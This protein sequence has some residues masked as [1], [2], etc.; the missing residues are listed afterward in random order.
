MA[1]KDRKPKRVKDDYVVPAPAVKPAP[2]AKKEEWAT[3]EVKV[4]SL[5]KRK[6]SEIAREWRAQIP[7]IQTTGEPPSEL[8]LSIPDVIA[9]ARLAK[10]A[11]SSLEAL[12]GNRAAVLH[13][14]IY[15]L[16]KAV[17]VEM[18][19]ADAIVKGRQTWGYVNGYQGA[20]FAL[21][22][23][24]GFLGVS[25]LRDPGGSEGVLMADVWP[26][27]ALSGRGLS[28]GYE[29][30]FKVVRFRELDHYQKWALLKRMLRQTTFTKQSYSELTATF[31][32]VGD[33]EYASHRNQVN[34]VSTAWL[35]DDLIVDAPNGPYVVPQCLQDYFDNIQE[36]TPNGTIYTMV[37]LIEMAC[38]FLEEIA[39][40]VPGA[41]LPTTKIQSLELELDVL[42]R[43]GSARSLLCA[44]DWEALP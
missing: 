25:I 31:E 41:G 19:V 26:E 12:P 43:R 18:E 14:A 3:W 2:V 38:G 10:R 28:S 17:H 42:K 37:A 22:A 15:M 40:I 20:L 30:E 8:F 39:T 27:E 33:R 21:T 36:V 44:L 35:S 29:Q 11:G 5:G 23:V 16:H 34:Y 13:E 6:F 1:R 32:K 9:K 24:L 7:T 4:E